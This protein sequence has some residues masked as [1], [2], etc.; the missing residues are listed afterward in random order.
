MPTLIHVSPLK[1]TL[2]MSSSDE[3][4]REKTSQ[5]FTTSISLHNRFDTNLRFINRYVF[6]RIHKTGS[7]GTKG[8]VNPAGNKSQICSVK[9]KYTSRQCYVKLLAVPPE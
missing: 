2:E 8:H 7:T 4:Q 6:I 9:F 1:N 5:S 3:S